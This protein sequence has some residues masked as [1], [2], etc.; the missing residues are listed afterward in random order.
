MG[1]PICINCEK[2]SS[3]KSQ[4]CRESTQTFLRSGAEAAGDKR[5]SATYSPWW[6]SQETV[7]LRSLQ[8]PK[9]GSFRR[10]VIR[11]DQRKF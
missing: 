8:A 4:E 5:S 7:D 9:L 2:I 3:P 10:E 11:V 1:P 6:R